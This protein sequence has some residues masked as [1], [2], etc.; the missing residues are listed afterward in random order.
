MWY[1]V[2]PSACETVVLLLYVLPATHPGSQHGLSI[3]SSSNPS[4]ASLPHHN[5][6]RTQN[7]EYDYIKLKEEGEKDP[8]V[9]GYSQSGSADAT[10]SSQSEFQY[11]DVQATT[12]PPSIEEGY[13]RESP[14]TGHLML[15]PTHDAAEEELSGG[16]GWFGADP[17][18]QPDTLDP[19]QEI[20]APTQ[21]AKKRR[22]SKKQR[23]DRRRRRGSK[24][25]KS[26]KKRVQVMPVW[27]PG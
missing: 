12:A 26:K 11:G 16:W 15:E 13:T 27:V 18:H 1:S 6:V 19:N 20:P 5:Q 4:D 25:K 7:L 3:S 9:A 10:M 8:N 22:R 14:E 21:E 23:K 24:P 2:V 17:S